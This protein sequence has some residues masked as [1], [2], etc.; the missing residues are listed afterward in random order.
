MWWK[1][2]R[3]EYPPNSNKLEILAE[4]NILSWINKFTFAN[5]LKRYFNQAKTIED[6][7]ESTTTNE[8]LQI[9]KTIFGNCDFYN[10]F[11]TQIANEIIPDLIWTDLKNLN[12]FLVDS[13]VQDIDSSDWHKIFEEL[14]SVKHRKLYG[15]YSTPQALARLLVNL[16]IENKNLR[17][18]DPCCGTGTIVK[19]AFNLKNNIQ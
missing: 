1:T 5:L 17:V 13:Y 11:K 15:Q 16:T 18:L 10:I 6:I 4:L 3:N 12:N 7:V 2:V 14:I 8:A 19:E 9:I